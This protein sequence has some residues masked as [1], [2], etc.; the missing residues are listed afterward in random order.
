MNSWLDLI[1]FAHPWVLLLLLLPLAGLLRRQVR[2]WPMLLRL[3]VLTALILALSG[4]GVGSQVETRWV[5]FLLDLSQS[6]RLA[7]DP[8]GLLAQVRQLAVPRPHTRYGLIVF[9]R[10]PLI[11]QSFQPTIA[12]REIHSTIDPLGSNIAAALLLALNSFPAEGGKS[13][14]LLSDGRSSGGELDQVLARARGQGVQIS[15]WPLAD[16]HS[17][18]WIA[19][20][21]APWQVS[22]QLP[23]RLQVQV[24]ANSYAQ[25]TLVIYRDGRLLPQ[26]RRKVKL[27]PG[28]NRFSFQDQLDQPGLYRYQAVLQVPGDSLAQ[29][30]KYTV[31]VEAQGGPQVLLISAKTPDE[32]VL[33]KLLAQ[34]GY[35]YRQTTLRQWQPSAVGLLSY[36]AVILDNAPLSELN[37]EQIATL[38]GYV[39]DQ[40]G[41]LLLIQGRSAVEGFDN[42]QFERILPLSY[43][44]PQELRL[45]PLAL[46]LVLDRSG[47]MGEAAGGARKLDLLKHAT[48]GTVSALAPRSLLGIIAFS[49]GHQ[50]VLSLGQVPSRASL[51]QAIGK[52]TAGGGTDLY[53]ALQAAIGALAKVQ[54]RVKH[55]IVFS[56]GKVAKVGKDFSRLFRQIRADGITASAIAIGPNADMQILQELRRAGQGKIYQVMDAHDLPRITLEELRRVVRNRWLQGSSPVLPG[57]AVGRLGPVAPARIP[58]LDGHVLTFPKPTSEVELIT[59]GQGEQPDALVSYWRYGLGQV[60]VLNTDLAGEGSG[61]WVRWSGLSRLVGQLLGQV[62]SEEPPQ[63]AQFKL[64]T[65]LSGGRLQATVE[66]QRGGRWLDRLELKAR[67]SQVGQAEIPL[68]FHQVAPGRYQASSGP[69]PQGVYLLQLQGA[70]AAGK[71][72]G[73]LRRAL[74]VPYPAEY[75][76]IGL[77]QMTLVHIAQQTGGRY[78]EGASKLPPQLLGHRVIYL[79]IWPALLL[80]GLALFL[81]DLITRKLPQRS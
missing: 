47:S 67:L 33:P 31:L 9:G 11:E 30:N 3:L 74:S 56:D 80:A 26:M 78:L 60:A 7:D 6:T 18:Y 66:A 57:P 19:R 22:Q 59:P 37:T 71:D 58:P 48:L 63:L 23:F 2:S 77:D 69:L 13:V 4:P 72:L 73:R 5:Y 12:V 42:K 34:A 38:S 32:S 25:D 70:S 64:Q 61:G 14:V 81:A 16:I 29:N 55:L 35:A 41:G 36:R 15:A 76:A 49:V 20:L 44:G 1:R 75:R 24:F 51:A 17:E 27:S 39:R 46:V 50:W 65:H 45:P 8:A 68:V 53:P 54:A 10:Q 52:L 40:G 21:Q 62:Y 79:E 43:E 28:L